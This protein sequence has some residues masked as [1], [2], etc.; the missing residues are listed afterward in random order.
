M[1]KILIVEPH[2]MLQ[3]AIAL[4]FFPDHEVKIAEGLPDSGA[5]AVEDY[6]VV[7]IDAAALRESSSLAPQMAQAIQSWPVPIIWLESEEEPAVIIREKLVVLRRPI[8][9][10]P[11]FAA[12]ALCLGR[13]AATPN[14]KRT[15]TD[16]ESKTHAE[17]AASKSASIEQ[18]PNVIDL[19]EVVEENLTQQGTPSQRA[20]KK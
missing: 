8:A 15:E 3:Q 17:A 12:L 11:L 13:S 20:G 4:S 19:V 18:E 14:T 16:K 10:E 7:V 6:D 1:S 9:R 5:A 2:R